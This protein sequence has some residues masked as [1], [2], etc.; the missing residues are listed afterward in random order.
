MWAVTLTPSVRLL[1]IG[2]C[3]P[4]SID[5]RDAT[6]KEYPRNPKGALVSLADFDMSVTA[7]QDGAVVGR[8]D[9][10]NAWAVCG[11]QGA[12]IGTTATITATYP[13]RALVEAGR[14]PGVAFQSSTTISLAQPPG[15]ANP[16]GCGSL[17]T[18]A[19]TATPPSSA[20][21]MPAPV[22]AATPGAA[23]AAGGAAGGGAAANSVAA[24]AAGGGAAAGRAAGAG[25][26]GG[27]AAG[28]GAAG[29]AAAGAAGGGAA[30]SGGAAGGAAAGR[31]AGAGAA[32]GAA[33]R[34]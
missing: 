22:V 33:D 20:V 34:R 14:V 31:A 29:S 15:T 28:G 12:A 23:T 16:I 13:G 4:I 8:Y 21:L 30:A 24:G 32:G 9:G 10:V 18:R 26:A 25:A 7:V 27:A 3:S 5:L 17:Q 1:T 2:N 11:C 19:P 6:G